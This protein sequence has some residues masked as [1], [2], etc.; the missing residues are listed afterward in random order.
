MNAQQLFEKLNK[1]S[2]KK[3]TATEVF[4][5]VGPDKT[6]FNVVGVKSVKT[7]TYGFFGWSLPCFVIN[8]DK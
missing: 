3:R 8:M 5:K 7:S 2:E 1:M 4:I 6:A